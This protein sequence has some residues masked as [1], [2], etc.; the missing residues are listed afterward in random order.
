[1]SRATVRSAVK[2]H[3]HGQVTNL[4]AVHKAKPRAWKTT[5]NRYDGTTPS[6]A[7]GYVHI[8]SVADQRAATGKRHLEY[9]VALVF[10][11]K[12][13]RTDA[14]LMMDEFDTL[15]EAIKARLRDTSA[16]PLGVSDGS[17]FE[18]AEHLLEDLTDEPQKKA[19]HVSMWGVIRFD[20][21]EWIT[22]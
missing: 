13:R 19:S 2:T 20:V 22:A 15:V 3:L 9:T 7:V 12:S 18:A 4:N 11:F 6:S 8:E 1:M 10:L 5:E 14:E 21:S 16:G 17:I